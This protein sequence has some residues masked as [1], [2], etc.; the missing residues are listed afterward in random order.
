MRFIGQI[1]AAWGAV[2]VFAILL[3]AMYRLSQRAVAAYDGG[4]S[5]GQWFVTA[6]LCVAMAYSE[7]YRGFQ[8][9]FSP[10]TA[11]R[12]RYLRD[13]PD[14]V[15]SLLAPLVAVGYLHATRKKKI[16]SYS[17]SLGIVVLV[18]LVQRVSQPWRGI[19][20]ASVVVGLGWGVLSLGASIARALSQATCDTPPEVPLPPS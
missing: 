9:S 2:G 11:A 14:T 8:L 12:I 17:L 20:D 1:G 18:V 15:R 3:F 7:G 4:L 16:R 10:S 13:R 6:V 5:P 19:I